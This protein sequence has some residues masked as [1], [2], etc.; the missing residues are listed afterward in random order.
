MKNPA[1]SV[2][3][4]SFNKVEFIKNTLKSI[5]YQKYDNVEVIVLDGGS[6]DGTLDI[7]KDFATKYPFIK[8]ES[9]RDKGQLDAINRGFAKAKGDLLTFINADDYYEQDTFRKISQVYKQGRNA[10]WFVGYG[11]VVDSHGRVVAKGT[12]WYKRLLLSLN[13]RTLLLVVNY[14]MQPSVFIG[15]EAYEKYGPFTGTSRY[16][17]EYDLWLKL[18]RICMPVVVRECLS[19]FRMS[20]T[21][22]SSEDYRNL[23][24]DDFAVVS[25]YTK[26]PLILLF[27]K[28]NNAGRIWV[29]KS[30]S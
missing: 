4:P 22:I 29:M 28:L 23:L 19:A 7:V 27:H 26:N 16:V 2:I 24:H 12:T 9:K 13:L 5:V 15:R 10:V 20:G 30:L 18:S 21:N 17:M 25:R 11:K 1:I 14:I 3:I 6:S 8:W